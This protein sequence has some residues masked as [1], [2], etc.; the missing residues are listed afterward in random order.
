MVSAAD[1][2][3]VL[4]LSDLPVEIRVQILGHLECLEE[5]ENAIRS[6]EVFRVA[7]ESCSHMVLTLMLENALHFDLFPLAI[8]HWELSQTR[9]WNQDH[10][11][12]W[13]NV[14]FDAMKTPNFIW[15]ATMEQNLDMLRF[16]KHV[17]YFAQEF[18]DWALRR[19]HENFGG[20]ET[21]ASRSEYDRVMR[22]LYLQS[23]IIQA[24]VS[25]G[26]DHSSTTTEETKQSAW[27]KFVSS[28]QPWEIEQ[29]RCMAQWVSGIIPLPLIC[30]S[31]VQGRWLEKDLPKEQGKELL[32]HHGL[33]LLR[34][35]ESIDNRTD[36]YKI[37][38]IRD[39][40]EDLREYSEKLYRVVFD[41][42]KDKPYIE[43]AE[44]RFKSDNPGP[45][46]LWAWVRADPQFDVCRLKDK[47][48]Y[49]QYGSLIWDEERVKRS[50]L[51]KTSVSR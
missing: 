48:G 23:I 33:A 6:S 11:E 4:S 29:L 9:W 39:F 28:F 24:T 37:Y 47:I 22:G 27:K 38:I 46:Q 49:P 7:Y 10:S 16:L 15:T 3:R 26:W 43:A 19:F 13:L 17:Q 50:R 45:K 18:I 35:V 1:E 31:C 42:L 41:L 44:P 30:Y 12:N 21:P 5:L 20:V 36:H 25:R 32:T 51:M 34:G 40:F 14:R 8:L 2:S